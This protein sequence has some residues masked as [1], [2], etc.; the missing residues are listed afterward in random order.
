MVNDHRSAQ[1]TNERSTGMKKVIESVLP[2]FLEL[3]DAM[4]ETRV[5]FRNPGT[6]LE[7]DAMDG[8]LHQSTNEFIGS[9]KAEVPDT[10]MSAILARRILD[11]DTRWRI[12][13]HMQCWPRAIIHFQALDGSAEEGPEHLTVF[14][15]SI[16]GGTA[17]STGRSL[18]CMIGLYW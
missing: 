9:R 4:I 7:C 8:Q 17:Y 13:Y 12:G 16:T 6:T 18:G 15:T 2:I 3:C 5:H 11:V 14:C 1:Y 10:R